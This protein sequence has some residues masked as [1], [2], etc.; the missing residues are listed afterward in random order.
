MPTR[1][2]HRRLNWKDT[3]TDMLWFMRGL[4]A[5]PSRFDTFDSNRGTKAEVF[6]F[7]QRLYAWRRLVLE[8]LADPSN[9]AVQQPAAKWLQ[10][11]ISPR[12]TKEWLDLVI[13]QIV[14][15]EDGSFTVRGRLARPMCGPD[16]IF[17]DDPGRLAN[18]DLMRQVVARAQ[19]DKATP[20]AEAEPAA[21]PEGQADGQAGGW[22]ALARELAVPEAAIAR[23]AAELEADGVPPAA[24]A[25]ALRTELMA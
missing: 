9:A 18:L 3:K 5:L 25:D 24:V 1:S 4:A 22:A 19:Q 15:F 20:W 16:I 21:E 11:A 17:E 2:H 12:V 14:P 13:L 23:R 8:D 7:R 6:A 10:Q